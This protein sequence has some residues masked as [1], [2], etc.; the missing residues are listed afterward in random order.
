MPPQHPIDCLGNHCLGNNGG[1]VMPATPPHS[2]TA[3]AAPQRSFP[4]QRGRRYDAPTSIGHQ[5]FNLMGLMRREVDVRLAEHGLT[6]AQWRPLWQLKSGRASTAIELARAL[7]VDAGAVTRMVH[8]LQSKGLVQRVRSASDRRVVHLRLTPEGE[9]AAAQIPPVLA[10]V[11]ND[12]LRG[13]SQAEWQ[14][15]MDLVSRMGASGLALAQ[16]R[17]PA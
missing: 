2:A 15:L 16:A 5:L 9:A 1:P 4:R 6:D 17:G 10:S 3:P 8:R 14:Q 11:N 13:F 12:F 7:A